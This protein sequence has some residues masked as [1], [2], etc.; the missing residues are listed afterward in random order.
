MVAGFSAVGE[1]GKPS[2]QVAE[3]ACLDFLA[4]ASHTEAAVDM[5][6]ADQLLMPMALAVGESTFTTCR[7]TSH[8]LTNAHVIRQFVDAR[9]EIEAEE[10]APGRIRVTGSPPASHL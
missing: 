2:E 10:A 7:V 8:L 4:F 9:I 5:H 6:L 1:R 3:E